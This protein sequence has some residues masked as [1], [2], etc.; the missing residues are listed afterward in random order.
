MLHFKEFNLE[1]KVITGGQN[2]LLRYPRPGG[3]AWI[4]NEGRIW[5]GAEG[6][7]FG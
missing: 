6:S 7:P 5:K 3:P 2:D 4:S 1:E